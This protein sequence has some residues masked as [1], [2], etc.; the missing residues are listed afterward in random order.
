MSDYITI[1]AAP[2][3]YA[4]ILDTTTGQLTQCDAVIAW[5]ITGPHEV[6]IPIGIGGEL[7]HTEYFQFPNGS[8]SDSCCDDWAG[9]ADA[10]A[11]EECAK[12]VEQVRRIVA[13]QAAKKAGILPLPSAVTA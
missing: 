12:R 13:I 9:M 10:N 4:L 3:F 2:G 11:P 1:P 6:P 8:V 7:T 5:K